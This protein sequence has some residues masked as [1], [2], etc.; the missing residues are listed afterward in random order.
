MVIEHGNIYLVNFDPSIG[1]EYQKV[2]PA[3]VIQSNTITTISPLITILPISTKT[4]NR[5]YHD[6]VLSKNQTNRLLHDSLIINDIVY[7]LIQD[8]L[9]TLVF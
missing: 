8:F 3:L 2:R 9:V 7:R 4:E 5:T 1:K 6:I